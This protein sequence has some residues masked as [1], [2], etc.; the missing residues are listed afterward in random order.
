MRKLVILA[1]SAILVANVSAQK[2]K[3]EC[4]KGKQLSKEERVE[5]DIKRLTNELMLSDEQAT[6]FAVTY[7]EYAGKLDELFQKNAPKEEFEPGKELTDK[8]LDALAKQRLEGFKALVDLQLK[9]YDKFRKNLSARQVEKVL[10]MKEPCG[11]KAFEGKPCCGKHEGQK[12]E[13]HGGRKF[14]KKGQLPEGFKKGA[15]PEGFPPQNFPEKKEG[16]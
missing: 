1:I 5:F 6:K 9:Y 12:C 16:L 15:R 2:E 13:G 7:R 10:S 14:E 3:K 11:P 8:E 4:F